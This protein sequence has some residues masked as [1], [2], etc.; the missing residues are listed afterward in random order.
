MSTV[1]RET[2]KQKGEELQGKLQE[3]RA[4]LKEFGIALAQY[5]QNQAEVR[6]NDARE[7]L[8]TLETQGQDLLRTRLSQRIP[9]ISQWEEKVTS[10]TTQVLGRV[11]P[12]LEKRVPLFLPLLT[13]VEKGVKI[14]SERVKELLKATQSWVEKGASVPI[15]GY[16][17][18]SAP[19]II[20]A[21]KGLNPKDL[22]AVRAYEAAHK[23]RKTILKE[24]DALLGV[25]SAEIP[26]AQA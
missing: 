1:T 21:L 3:V 10:Q 9:Q 23:N 11:R 18:K 17:E 8:R 26:T 7:F 24:I 16:D 14:L 15:Q 4:T 19:E 20:Q 25:S 6:L 5:A 12:E 22:E 13:G 2:L